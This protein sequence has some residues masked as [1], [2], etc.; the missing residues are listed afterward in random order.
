MDKKDDLTLASVPRPSP[1]LKPHPIKELSS[2]DYHELDPKIHGGSS[3]VYT[4]GVGSDFPTV[5]FDENK[6]RVT[7]ADRH[8]PVTVRAD[9]RRLLLEVQATSLNEST[10]SF[11]FTDY[12]TATLDPA[13]FYDKT[14]EAIATF[15]M[16]INAIRQTILCALPSVAITRGS[17]AIN[18]TTTPNDILAHTLMERVHIH[19]PV[20]ACAPRQSHEH[21]TNYN[22][23]MLTLHVTCP[24]DP[25][26]LE[27]PAFKRITTATNAARREKLAHLRGTP[28]TITRA[29]YTP[30]PSET[31]THVW[32]EPANQPSHLE[33]NTLRTSST[34]LPA[35]VPSFRVMSSELRKSDDKWTECASAVELCRMCPGDELKLAVWCTVGM[36]A[37]AP[38]SHTRFQVAKVAIQDVFSIDTS[39]VTVRA[40]QERIVKLCPNQGVFDI[41]D[42]VGGRGLR[43]ARSERCDGCGKCVDLTVDTSATTLDDAKTDTARQVCRVWD[44]TLQ[45]A[46]TGHSQVDL[47]PVKTYA[48]LPVTMR[49]IIETFTP[50]V[51]GARPC[52]I[53]KRAI[54]ALIDQN[55]QEDWH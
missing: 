44:H 10:V 22:S 43:V 13:H 52:E 23:I 2:P 39:E 5:A 46:V 30:S 49:M 35:S 6:G 29:T 51:D 27:L 1:A 36:P 24:L 41:E 42:V 48:K 26:K 9:Y 3:Y 25:T 31:P 37:G 45:R 53:L 38:D 11:V 7:R 8:D 33:Y 34:A 17:I 19:I 4:F 55:L 32:L 40:Q 16:M 28:K 20:S 15:P 47:A 14:K 21:L 54:H 18:T 12:R 50:G